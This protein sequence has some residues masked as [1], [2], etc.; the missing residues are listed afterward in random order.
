[1]TGTDNIW[2][3]SHLEYGDGGSITA[4]L[5]ARAPGHGELFCG[6]G[7]LQEWRSDDWG[8]RWRRVGD[9]N[10]PGGFLANNPKSVEDSSG[11]PLK[12]TLLLF[13]LQGPRAIK[14]AG[15]FCGQAYLWRKWEAEKETTNHTNITNAQRGKIRVGGD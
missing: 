6:G 2:N 9:L 13:G 14:P 10:L 3:A 4:F 11:A 5:V 8:K 1:M 12:R 7:L 15:P